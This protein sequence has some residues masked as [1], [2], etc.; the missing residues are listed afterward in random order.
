VPTSFNLDPELKISFKKACANRET[1]QTDVVNELIRQWIDSNTP[2]KVPTE[3]APF[4]SGYTSPNED[5]HAKLEIILNRGNERDRTGIEQNLDWAVNDIQSRG[6][7]PGSRR[8]V[9]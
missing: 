6:R 5:W 8:K 2:L 7:K 9:G 3:P 1:T 4:S